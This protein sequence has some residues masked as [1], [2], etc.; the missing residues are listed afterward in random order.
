[1]ALPQ[2]E[3]I[4]QRDISGIKKADTVQSQHAQLKIK[5]GS[6][7]LLAASSWIVILLIL[8]SLFGVL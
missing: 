1:M 6:F 3:N 4:I 5:F 8:A 2:I 7:F